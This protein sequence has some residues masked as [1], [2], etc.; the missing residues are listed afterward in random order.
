M[1]TKDKQKTSSTN[2]NGL[3]FH[4]H[5]AGIVFA[6]LAIYEIFYQ[7]YWILDTSM[8][9]IGLG[10]FLGII[11]YALM[12]YA[13]LRKINGPL[14]AIG[15]AL[16]AYSSF[17]S[18]IL[19]QIPL[20]FVTEL[21][22][23][24]VWLMALIISLTHLTDY[25]PKLKTPFAKLWP[26]PGIIHVIVK[27]L[28]IAIKE[29]RITNPSGIITVIDYCVQIFVL[30]FAVIATLLRLTHPDSESAKKL[31]SIEEMYKHGNLTFLEYDLLKSNL[32]GEASYAQQLG[33][34]LTMAL[35]DKMEADKA[36]KKHKEEAQNRVITHAAIGNAVGGLAGG[37][38]GAASAA[39]KANIETER[40]LAEQEKANK[41]YEEA[42][43]RSIK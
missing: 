14:I 30:S 2:N 20:L 23:T 29:I 34:D 28:E 35:S 5:T 41:R 4:S 7:L 32:T 18:M 24:I 11:T 40:L 36:L 3:I 38:A 22:I 13:L 21:A 19:L 31:R 26:I 42:L 25:L 43:K 37:I 16:M 39:T 8:P 15:F 10:T 33:I 6:I 9:I 17:P 27:I 12:A 1:D